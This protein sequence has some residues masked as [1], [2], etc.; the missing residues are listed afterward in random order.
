MASP[1]FEAAWVKPQWY[2]ECALSG[3]KPIVDRLYV[4]NAIDSTMSEDK[5]QE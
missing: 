4:V 1:D 2:N 5:H 3:Q